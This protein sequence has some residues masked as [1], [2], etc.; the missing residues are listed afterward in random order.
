MNNPKIRKKEAIN[1]KIWSIA[2]K[3]KI[4]GYG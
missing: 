4:F 1:K 3:F 2:G